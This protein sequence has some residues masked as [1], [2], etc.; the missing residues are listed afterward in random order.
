MTTMQVLVPISGS[1]VF[2]PRDEFYFSKPMVDVAGRP[3]VEVVVAQLRR[4]FPQARFFFVV[5]Q[6]DVAEFSID[7]ILRLAA[8]P[9]AV[10]I[11]RPGPTKG[12]LCSCLLAIDAIDHDAPL[13]VTNSDQIIEANL[14]ALVGEIEGSAADAGVLTFPST[15]PRWSYVVLDAGGDVIQAAEKRVLSRDAIAGL[16]YF[17]TAGRF[18]RAAEEAIVSGAEDG[19][20]YFI[21]AALNEITLSGGRVS[22]AEI[23]A[24]RYHSFYSPSRI[25]A[26]ERT[27]AAAA[28]RRDTGDVDPR[29]H[30]VVPASGHGSRFAKAGWR[31]PK[32]FIDVDGRMMLL[33]VLDNVR[34][35]AGSATV[36]L[37]QEHLD[38]YPHAIQLLGDAD[39]D[40]EPVAQ[41]TEGTACTVLLA[42]PRFDDDVPLLVANSDQ[43]VDFDVDD[44]VRDCI[45]RDLDGSILVF[46]DPTMD[47]KWSFAKVDTEGLVTEVA[48]KIAISDLATV[49]IYLFRRGSDFVRGAADMIARN[50]R[51]NG[52]FY[53]APVYNHLIAGGLRIGVYE[54]AQTAMHG[55]GTPDDL[56]GYLTSIGAPAS[57]DAP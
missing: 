23:E 12:A 47:P 29:V 45:N 16:Y 40:I 38:V 10:I 56:S 53:T 32:P 18:F 5:D 21:S 3:M 24:R 9:D 34:P 11:E 41:V 17:S 54:V 31:K 2:F 22:R 27:R 28:V 42:R 55:L 46:R 19:G 51:V 26:F 44:Y 36:L 1:S 7:R 4:A 20:D 49:G 43:L 35:S 15:S 57:T 30:L 25:E 50:E 6:T 14:A 48:E 39:A 8:G 52:E 37:R 13:I 33:R